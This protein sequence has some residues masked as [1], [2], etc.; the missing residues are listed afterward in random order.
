MAFG[1]ILAA[2]ELGIRIPDDVSLIGVDDHDVAAV[3]GLT[4]VHQ[5]VA[6]HGARAARI[7]IEQLTEQ[8]TTTPTGPAPVRLIVRRT[9]AAPRAE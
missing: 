5:D 9:T 2:E 6:E 3:V 7:A 8:P 4:T 1:V